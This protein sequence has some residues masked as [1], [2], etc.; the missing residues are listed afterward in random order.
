M[1]TKIIEQLRVSQL[2]PEDR[3]RAVIAAH[4]ELAYLTWLE[5]RTA[6]GIDR[7]RS[8]VTDP[9][10]RARR[11]SISRALWQVTRKSSPAEVAAFT[12]QEVTTIKGI[13]PVHAQALV[14][15]LNTYIENKET[16]R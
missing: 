7:G 14:L 4:P 15:A 8:K 9:Q 6:L 2:S 16:G 12:D 13:G 11:N 1:T 5:L 10:E 3:Q